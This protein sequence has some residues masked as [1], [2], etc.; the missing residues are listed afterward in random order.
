[1]ILVGKVGD[2]L[3]LARVSVD[4]FDEALDVDLGAVE[5]HFLAVLCRR[6]ALVCEYRN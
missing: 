3:Q 2:L 6:L 5:V 4:L 1:V